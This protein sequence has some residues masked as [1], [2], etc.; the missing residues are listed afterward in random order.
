MAS[1]DDPRIGTI[2]M[3]KLRVDA[4]LG[5]GGM[6]AVY[7]V[8][9][10]VTKHDRALKVLHPELA[11]D[12]DVIKRLTREAGVAGTLRSPHVV[13]TLDV[14]HL[15]DDSPFVLMELL[16][17]ESLADRMEQGEIP[18][19]DLITFVCQACQGVMH[20]H[21]AGIVHRDLK[22]EN[23]FIVRS[24]D[25]DERIKILDF[26]ISKFQVETLEDGSVTREGTVLGT[27][28]YMSPE[29]STGQADLGP[30]TDIYSL[31]VILYEGLSGSTPHEALNFPQLLVQLNTEPPKPLRK[32]VPG[33]DPELA[34][35]VDQA[36]SI[37]PRDRPASAEA[38][39]RALAPFADPHRVQDLDALRDAPQA[40]PKSVMI[41]MADTMAGGLL[42]ELRPSERPPRLSSERPAPSS[43]PPARPNRTQ[44]IE[45]KPELAP[46]TMEVVAAGVPRPSWVPWAIAA[47]A[48]LALIA[49]IAFF[50]GEGGGDGADPA[51][52]VAQE[53]EP[54]LPEPALHEPA[55]HEAALPDP[56]LPEGLSEP[57]PPEPTEPEPTL[58]E[59]AARPAPEPAKTGGAGS[60]QK[61]STSPSSPSRHDIARENP[62]E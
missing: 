40:A 54:A 35:V 23:L 38:L 21:A 25:G 37:N 12:E 41:S 50:Y 26:G 30:A 31:G 11:K 49:G 6:G 53:P 60:A 32:L 59:P 55:L 62:Y 4:L 51:P 14:G 13:E 45:P 39:L 5:A 52:T 3:D 10:L 9:H 15:D 43:P 61:R 44:T 48:A 28:L 20:A 33:I 29:Q 46:S 7:R 47:A 2:V 19:K 16:D 36:L 57:A 1:A 8:H 22:P 34:A 56:T 27:P 24:P 42:D 58:P 17:G 18:K